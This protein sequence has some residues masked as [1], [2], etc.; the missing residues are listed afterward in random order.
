VD[1][2]G[3]YLTRER[4]LRAVTRAEVAQA[5]RLPLELLVAL[6]EDRFEALHGEAFAVGAIRNYARCIGL[7][8]D[9]AVLRFQEMVQEHRAAE[10]AGPAEPAA[11]DHAALRRRLALGALVLALGLGATLALRFR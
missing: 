4:E 3:K 6:E 8:E 2:F 11:A 9:D 5:T 7:N 1:S 10:P